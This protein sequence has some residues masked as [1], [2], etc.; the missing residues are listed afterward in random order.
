MNELGN[1]IVDI[2]DENSTESDESMEGFMESE[3]SENNNDKNNNNTIDNCS[4]T[5]EEQELQDLHHFMEVYPNMDNK[6]ETSLDLQNAVTML[7]SE[8][9][10]N[11]TFNVKTAVTTLQ[12]MSRN[13][14]LYCCDTMS[15]L[16]K[17][18][19]KKLGGKMGKLIK[20]QEKKVI[21]EETCEKIFTMINKYGTIQTASEDLTSYLK[22]NK[23]LCK[24]EEGA[25]VA[26]LDKKW[27]PAATQRCW[28]GKS[29][30][31]V[32]F[33][34]LGM[35]V[36]LILFLFVLSVKVLYVFVSKK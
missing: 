16:M 23:D 34:C 14:L 2:V 1:E 10:R 15:D 5:K 26:K 36:Y 8:C 9:N 29:L 28:C 6:D 27:N 32:F 31:L 35:F 25:E 33:L 22:K 11:K 24:S 4:L 17:N 21:S 3:N 19:S 13:Y 18:V 12:K 20:L 30:S 7:R